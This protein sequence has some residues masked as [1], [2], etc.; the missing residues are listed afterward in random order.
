MTDKPTGQ[1]DHPDRSYEEAIG[2]IADDRIAAFW[3]E[4]AL[5]DLQKA[6]TAFRAEL[7]ST[8]T[9]VQ[10]ATERV[11]DKVGQHAEPA[12]ATEETAQPSPPATRADKLDDALTRFLN[13][14]IR[15]GE[16]PIETANQV[17]GLRNAWR[18]VPSTLNPQD[19]TPQLVRN[20]WQG[21][22]DLMSFMAQT[23]APDPLTG[24]IPEAGMFG[25]RQ[26]YRA[27][28]LSKLP[29]DQVRRILDSEPDHGG[30]SG[31]TPGPMPSISGDEKP[32][33]VSS[34]SGNSRH[35]TGF[36]KMVAA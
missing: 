29:E 36:G 6:L 22:P 34:G 11:L 17:V 28:L 2:R 9:I 1:D 35:E 24:A 3:R 18:G 31:G 14:A 30:P 20:L 12:P 5:P 13:M 25:Y 32:E 8:E 19:I 33:S 10:V 16:N 15:Y 4:T 21:N 26:G 27:G 23:M 7:P